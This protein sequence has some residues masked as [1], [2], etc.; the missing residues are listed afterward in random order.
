M[1]NSGKLVFAFGKNSVRWKSPPPPI[2]MYVGDR[3]NDW[4]F[5]S[6]QRRRWQGK[7]IRWCRAKVEPKGGADENINLPRARLRSDVIADGH[8]SSARASPLTPQKTKQS[9]TSRL[10]RLSFITIEG[11]VFITLCVT[12][13]EQRRMSGCSLRRSTVEITRERKNS[14]AEDY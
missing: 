9:E 11:I 7:K 3:G 10:P 4:L 12:H 8:L 2:L 5:A 13:K 6:T 14:V 1:T